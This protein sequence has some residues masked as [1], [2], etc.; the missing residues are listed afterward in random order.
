MDLPQDAT[1]FSLTKVPLRRIFPSLRLLLPGMALSIILAILATLTSREIA[2]LTGIA[3]AGPILL[4]ILFGIVVR[5]V[6]P[7][8]VSLDPGISF[9]FRTLLRVGIVGL[10]FDFSARALAG[11][12][13]RGLILDLSII[14]SVYL[15]ALWFGRLRGLPDSLSLLLG[16]GTAICGASAIVA[17]N[18]VIRGKDEEVAYSVA[19]VTLFGTLSMFLYPVVRRLLHLPPE[20]YGAWSGASIHEIG[21]VV[22]ATLPYSKEALELATLLKLTRVALLLPVILLLEAYV[23]A[24]ARS[25]NPSLARG[26][27]HVPWFVGAFAGVVLL[28]FLL[29][30]PPGILHLLQGGDAA[31][32]AVAMAAMGLETYLSRILRF[33]VRPLAS[34][35]FLWLFVSVTGLALAMLLYGHGSLAAL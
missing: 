9:S 17:A 20:V 8:P 21:Q 4:A 33:G 12:G 31:I 15:A 2:K 16:T 28:N 18:G 27:R 34:G 24:R 10:G 1:A 35:V 3:V 30:L 7:L 14:A 6:R 13:L 23:L 29:P 32:L 26:K 25:E 22:G 19:T 11:I 5:N